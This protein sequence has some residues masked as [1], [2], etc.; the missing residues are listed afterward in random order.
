MSA[1]LLE[2]LRCYHLGGL[3]PMSHL[4]PIIWCPGTSHKCV[5]SEPGLPVPDLV[6]HAVLLLAERL[7]WQGPLCSLLSWELPL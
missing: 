5:P 6:L 2:A 4:L 1:S 3:R 7:G